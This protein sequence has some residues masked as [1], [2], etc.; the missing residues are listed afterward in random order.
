MKERCGESCER[1]PYIGNCRC[2]EDDD[3][4]DCE[5]SQEE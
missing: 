3:D 5:S 1:C 4:D 2:L